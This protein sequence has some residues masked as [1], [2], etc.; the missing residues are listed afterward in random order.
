M[1][2]AKA[3]TET[4]Y[5]WE[6]K[7]KQGHP[8][9][10]ELRASGAA[11]VSVTLRRQGVMTTRVRKKHFVRGK[12]ITEKELCLFTRQ[13]ATMMKAGVP[14][15]Q[16]FEIVARGH[17][18][19]SVA[20]LLLDIRADVETGTSLQQAF[21]R[22]PQYFDM[23]FCN[24]VA[25]GEQAGILEELLARLALY[26]EKT[27]SIKGKIR[28][29]MF[30]PAAVLTVAFVVTAII[31]IWVVPAFK[32]VFS[33]FG[34]EL[35]LPTLAV[36][37]LSDQFVRYWYMVAAA[38][39]IGSSLFVRAWKR[40]PAM[41]A[42]TDRLLLRLP[43]FGGVVRKAIIARWTRTLSTMFAAGVPLV[44]S[45]ESVAGAA[46]NAVYHEAT[47]KITASVSSGTSLT[48]AMQNA[49]VFPSM[50]TQMVAIGEESGAL[51]QML[52]KVAEFHE[53]EV[54]AEVASLSS[55]MEPVIMVILG[56]LIGGLV[57]AMYMPIF[58]L[59]SVV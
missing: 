31:M 13:L 2:T 24:L 48:I 39:V 35:P 38:L 12:K 30:Y 28:A 36:I 50:V 29:A 15:L 47:R 20:R 27:L 26:K 43:I 41:Q 4:I 56:V 55:L 18:N 5:R 22:Y 3:G 1:A 53:D 16:S 45:L 34:A 52:N 44:E 14:L 7:D 6:G 11:S 8:V 32:S 54:D 33:S 10:G 57:I 23:L 17:A 59:G 51:D 49:Q 46:G 37:W 19:P 9:Q 25:A 40:S 42:A 21:R 58:K